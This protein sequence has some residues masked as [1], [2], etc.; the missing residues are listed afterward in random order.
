MSE[1]EKLERALEK[2]LK[3]QDDSRWPIH[4]KEK[5]KNKKI[6]DDAQ[7]D[8]DHQIYLA[9]FVIKENYLLNLKLGENRSEHDKALWM[10]EFPK[11]FSDDMKEF[12][13]LIRNKIEE[14]KNVN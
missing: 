6:R 3:I 2:L 13:K 8:L 14:L 4:D 9:R 11:Y 12:I 1:I 10:S 5:G 7:R